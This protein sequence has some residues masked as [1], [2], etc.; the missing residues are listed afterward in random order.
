VPIAQ[1]QVLSVSYDVSDPTAQILGTSKPL[2][3]RGPR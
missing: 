3:S 2:V 1:N